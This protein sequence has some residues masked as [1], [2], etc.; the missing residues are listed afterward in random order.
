MTIHIA[1]PFWGAYK[2]YGWG[3]RIPGIG[4][5]EKI[6][7]QALKNH[8]PIR[9]TIGKDT[10]EYEISPVTVVNLAKKYHSIKQVRHGVKVAV[11]PQNELRKING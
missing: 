3:E 9:L 4:L 8:E 11:I 7:M 5:A 6:V 10:A 1:E 2:F